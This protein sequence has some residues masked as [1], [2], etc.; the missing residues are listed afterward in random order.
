M[1]K[2]EAD[3]REKPRRS[4]GDVGHALAKGLVGAVPIAGSTA[5]ELF[6]LIVAPPLEK[7]RER[8]LEEVAS[9]VQELRE[10]I[11]DLTPEKLSQDDRF[12]TTLLH[13]TQVALRTHQ[14]EKLDALRNAVGNSAVGNTPEEDLRSLFLNFIEEFTPTHLRILKLIQNKTSSNLP[15]LRDLIS[16]RE[17]TDQVVLGLARNGMLDDSRPYAARGRDTGESL[18]TFSW[19]VSKLGDQFLAFISPSP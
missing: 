17:M 2:E 12:V 14:K 18:L 8:W 7:R 13:A 5:A 19:T 16:Q 3:L 6:A 15:L 9:A 11:K 1:S 10:K 4:A